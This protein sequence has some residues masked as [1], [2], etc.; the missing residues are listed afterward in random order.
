MNADRIRL[1]HLCLAALMT[2][3]LAGAAFAENSQE[4]GTEHSEAVESSPIMH[5]PLDGSSPEALSANL[6]KIRQAATESE[7]IRLR[8]A[9]GKMRMYDLSINHN[10]AKLAAAVDGRTPEEVIEASAALWR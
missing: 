2:L 5:E 1:F 4:S 10:S 6:E 9:L 3:G 7:F 8:N